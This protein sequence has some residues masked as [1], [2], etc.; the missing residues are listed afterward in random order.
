MIFGCSEARHREPSLRRIELEAL[1]PGYVSRLARRGMSV[2]KLFKKYH[3]E[4]PNGFPAFFFQA[5]HP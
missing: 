2:R 5:G 3:A 4:Y 1:L